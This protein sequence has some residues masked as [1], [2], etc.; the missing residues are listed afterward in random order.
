M[1]WLPVLLTLAAQDPRNITAGSLIPDEGY[2][3]QPYI[4]KADDGAWV[5]VITTG[6]GREGAGGQHVVTRRSLDRGKTWSQPVDVEPSDG[7]E[8][9]Y[10]V[11]LK[12]PSGRLYVFYNHNT[13]NVRQVIADKPAFKDG[14]CRRVDSLGHFVFK[15]SD[16]HGRSWSARRYDIPMRDF[17][18]D[19]RNPY[20][21]KLK[22]F[23]NVGRAFIH[24]NA[25]Y[26]PLH[27]VG[28]FGEGFF[29]SSEGALLRSLNI[30]TERDPDKI[31]WQ[32]LPEGETGL[33]TPPGGGPVAEE[34]SFTP[35]SD[36][37]LFV[38]YRTIDGHSVYSYSRD[39]GRT[40]D[41][42]RYMTFADGRLMKHPRAANFVWRCNNGNYLYW[43]HNHGGRFIRE[44]PRRR[45]IA[46]E[47]RNPVWLSGGVEADSP[48]GKIIRWSEPEIA[49]YDDDPFIRMSYPDLVEEDGRYYLTETQKDLAR[50]HEIAR[51]LLEGLWNPGRGATREGLV[52]EAAAPFTSPPALP[53]LPV[54]VKRGTG[55]DYGHEDLRAGVSFDLIVQGVAAE[56]GRILLSNRTP[57]G[58]GFVLHTVPGGALEL[59]VNDGRTENR[60]SSDPG[61]LR[62][63][64][65]QH[66]TA[67][68]DGGPKII[69]FIVDGRVQ[70]GGEARQFG[71]GR[72]SPALR[73]V[74]GSRELKVGPGVDHVRIYN[75]ALRTAEAIAAF[76]AP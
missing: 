58:R 14:F 53:P 6:P 13:D 65:R 39:D 67:I 22:F 2:S 50:T 42:P 54:F 28:G 48:A 4:V 69:R 74:E 45:S 64:S 7:P 1:L 70:D 44:H 35:L 11:M 55:G 63:G 31:A 46:Y 60:W 36:G 40:W 37:S 38:V 17:E 66:I 8:A 52:L 19:R 43:F 27:K 73:D 15:Y 21:G 16:D 51:P 32:T 30:L 25:G 56:P 61:T 47:D 59:I 20:Q 72:F 29:T 71:W 33:R 49:L 5:V 24:R 26:V 18:I 9:S 57:E 23:W 68:V 34:Q 12:V 75:R 62:P 3:D 10:A 41:A 76:R